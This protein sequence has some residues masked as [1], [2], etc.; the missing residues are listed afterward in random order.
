MTNNNTTTRSTKMTKL[1]TNDVQNIL[2][3]HYGYGSSAKTISAAYGISVSH[4]RKIIN[5]KVWKN[6]RIK[7]TSDFN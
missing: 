1:T 2:L 5:R 7:N 4:A 6:V 3:D